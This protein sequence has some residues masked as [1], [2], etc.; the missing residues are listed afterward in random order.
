MNDVWGKWRPAPPRAVSRAPAS[1]P[2][3]SASATWR[4]PC[5]EVQPRGDLLVGEPLGR[6]EDDLRPH[7]VAIR[8]R[9]LGGHPFQGSP[10]ILRE[11]DRVGAPSPSGHVLPRLEG[12]HALGDTAIHHLIRCEFRRRSAWRVFGDD[13]TVRQSRPHVDGVL[14]PGSGDRRI[15]TCRPPGLMPC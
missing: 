1:P 12:E 5:G 9:I 6:V 15:R 14:W 10:F 7:H 8:G 2:H 3:R 11:L 4:P 13:P